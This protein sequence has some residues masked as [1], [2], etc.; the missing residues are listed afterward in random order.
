SAGATLSLHSVGPGN[1]RI[2]IYRAALARALQPLAED[3]RLI[4]V[5]GSGAPQGPQDSTV[6][7]SAHTLPDAAWK[8]QS[9]DWLILNDAG[10]LDEASAASKAA[11]RAWFLGGGRIF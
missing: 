11:L 2:E 1:A 6:T 9:V 5:G 3:G 7:I 4:L 10:V 8:W